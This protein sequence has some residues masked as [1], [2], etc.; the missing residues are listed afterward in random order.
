M[1]PQTTDI[2][3]PILDPT[4]H[5]GTVSVRYLVVDSTIERDIDEDPE[6]VA[7]IQARLTEMEQGEFLSFEEVFGRPFSAQE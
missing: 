1:T 6:F 7:E 3:R 4:A 5:H 2:D